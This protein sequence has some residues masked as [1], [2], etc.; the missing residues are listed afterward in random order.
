VA[1]DGP[2][3]HEEGISRLALL[4][5]EKLKTDP[6]CGHLFVFRGRRGDRAT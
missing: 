4:V 5:Q 6:H 2:H 3:R 1:G